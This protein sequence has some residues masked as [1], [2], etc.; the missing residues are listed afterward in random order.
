MDSV[1]RYYN[2]DSMVRAFIRKNGKSNIVYLG[3]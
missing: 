2:L 1:T 3:A